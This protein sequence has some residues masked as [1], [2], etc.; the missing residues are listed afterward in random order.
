DSS[1]MGWWP[2]HGYQP[3]D[4]FAVDEHFGT[5][6]DLRE[7]VDEAHRRGLKV[8]LDMVCNQVA[9]DHPWVSDSANWHGRGYKN[10][11]HE[12]SG[13]DASTSIQDWHDQEQLESRELHGMPDLAQ[14]N[15]HVYAFLLDMAKYWIELS[16]CD[17]FRLD[18]VK[19]APK[20]F[21]RRYCADLHRFA[22]P[23]FF[24][25]G[26]VF[27]GSI[28]YLAR[29]ADLGFNALFD[30]PL[31][32]TISRVFGQGASVSLLS[33][34]VR[35]N[36]ARLGHVLL[37]PLIDNHDMARFAHWARDDAKRKTALA[38]AFLLTH[39]GVPMLYYGTEVALEGAEPV[40]PL[41]GK[42]QDYLNRLMMPWQRVR[43]EDA[44]LV[45][46]CRRLAHLRQ[47]WPAV[48]HGT[49]VELYVDHGTYCYLRSLPNEEVMVA[50]NTSSYTEERTIP[51]RGTLFEGI[52]RVVDELTGQAFRTRGDSL[53]LHMAPRCSY[54]FHAT[55]AADRAA[56]PP[57]VHCAF[58]DRLTKDFRRVPFVYTAR[59]PASTVAVA[60][61]FNAW[62]ATSHAM[63]PMDSSKTIW[64]LTIPLRE[65]RYRYKFVINGKVWTHDPAAQLQ[66][67]DPYGGL[68]SVVLVR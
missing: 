2:Y 64:G 16:G 55:A 3:V 42:P 7:L 4:F 49:T 1:F 47:K 14:E 40:D 22:G 46:H 21:W 36:Q 35:A 58:T 30:I 5:A 34:H 68:N 11:F 9:P 31:S 50:L 41:T 66:E 20:E 33:A 65:G 13:R 27:D 17:G 37:S 52:D 19:H 32:Y 38:L 24:L 18:A 53:D 45:A 51:L 59:E 63:S 48:R 39:E 10:W 43:G 23:D 56:R 28:D 57:L 12:H 54:L 6:E 61:D 62:N 25:L 67:R 29:Y 8:I 15:P 26:E 60:G 44:D